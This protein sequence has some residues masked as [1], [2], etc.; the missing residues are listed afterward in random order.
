MQ[1][2]RRGEKSRPLQA[3]FFL[4]GTRTVR[5]LNDA[6]PS[7]CFCHDPG[8]LVEEAHGFKDLTRNSASIDLNSA[9]WVASYTKLMT[10]VATLQLVERGLVDLD[11]DI[12]RVLYEWKDA[13]V[14]TGFDESGKP[15]T[16]PSK[17]KMTLRWAALLWHIGHLADPRLSNRQLLTHSAGMGYDTMSPVVQKYRQAVGLPVISPGTGQTLV[18]TFEP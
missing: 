12:T 16:R 1:L 5:I 2:D 7:H 10:T 4:L 11:E 14:L 9:F 15:I 3:L 8:V 13:T 18:R 17:N 6:N